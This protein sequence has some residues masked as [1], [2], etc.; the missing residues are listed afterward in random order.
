MVNDVG[1]DGE[2]DMAIQALSAAELTQLENGLKVM[3]PVGPSVAFDV[4]D[5]EN[6][7]CSIWPKALPILKLVAQY[8]GFIPGVGGTAAIIVNALITAGNG[9]SSVI[10]PKTA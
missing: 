6:D 3:A 7:F 2:I 10:C 9:V 4:S 5:L 8:I 1:L